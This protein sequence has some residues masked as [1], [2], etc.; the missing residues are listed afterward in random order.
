MK[1]RSFNSLMSKLVELLEEGE[2]EQCLVALGTLLQRISMTTKIIQDDDGLIYSQIAMFICGDKVLGSMPSPFEI[3][4][5]P[6]MTATR[7]VH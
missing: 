2:D 7:T 5:V 3:P 4:M 1:K 6:A